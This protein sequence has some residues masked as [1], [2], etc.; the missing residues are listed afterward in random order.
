MMHKRLL[1]LLLVALILAACG[2]PYENGMQAYE[3]GHWKEAIK[4]FQE[5]KGWDEHSEEAESMI[6]KASFNIG[7]A[8][9]ESGNWDEALEYLPEAKTERYAEAKEMIGLAYY[10]KGREAIEREDWSAAINNLLMVRPEC[11]CYDDARNLLVEAKDHRT[12]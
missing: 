12:G 2:S 6:A 5:V 3:K 7:K 8:A 10:N 9:Y 4:H 11:S 1:P